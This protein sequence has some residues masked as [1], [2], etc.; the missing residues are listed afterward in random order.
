M[1]VSPF[2]VR[3]TLKAYRLRAGLSQ[4]ELADLVQVRRQTIYDME[5]GR[6]M[7]NTAVALRLSQVL[8]CSVET[9]FGEES[10][11]R[12]QALRLAMPSMNRIAYAANLPTK[13]NTTEVAPG[14]DPVGLEQTVLILGC[15]PAL[16]L[17]PEQIRRAAP[18]IHMHT[19]FASSRHALRSLAVGVA[20]AAGIHYH[21]FGSGEAN[22]EA[23]RTALQARPCT[24]IGFSLQEEGLL[25]APGNPLHI[26]DVVDLARPEVRLA[27]RE[28]GAALRT[29]LDSLLRSRGISPTDLGPPKAEVYS[30]AEGAFHILCGGADAALG[31]RLVA[32]AFG[33]EFIPLAITRCDLVVPVE[34]QTRCGVA[35]LLDLLQSAR[36]RRALRSLPGYDAA[37]TGNIISQPETPGIEP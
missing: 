20:H 30:H 1:S 12:A 25:V 3:C 36:L 21:N 27:V 2:P 26:H 34:L 24:L 23:T 19:L 7:P 17:V 5:S 32:K 14:P 11:S 9:L 16:T 13:V 35:A 29:L 31:L 33:L 22:L 28:E 18:G 10:T 37:A 4:E 6:Y 15:D 8:D